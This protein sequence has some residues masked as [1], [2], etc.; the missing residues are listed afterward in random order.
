MGAEGSV[1]MMNRQVARGWGSL[2]SMVFVLAA[3]SWAAAPAATAS[4]ASGSLLSGGAAT[5]RTHPIFMPTVGNQWR[6]PGSNPGALA[7]PAPPCPESG[8][9]PFLFSN[10]GLPEFPA[11]GQP[12]LG[13]MAYWGGHVQVH[14]KIY[15]V[16]WGWG[17]HGAFS[18]A[19]HPERLR[20]GRMTATLP[21]DPDGAGKR[22]A[23]FVDQL[24]GT[25]WAG[26]QTQ[27]YQTVG[28]RN[29]H[30]TNPKDQ[31]GGIWVDDSS[32]LDIRRYNAPTIVQTALGSGDDGGK[33]FRQMGQEAARAVAHF[34][35]KD[36]ADADIVVAQ[37]Q[38]FSDPVA[39]SVGYCAFHDY[40]EPGVEHGQYDG[41]TPGISYTNMPY[42]LNNGAGCGK[43]FVNR[44]GKLDGVTIVL[45]HEI[46]ETVTDPGAEQILPNGKVLSAWFDPFD[47]NENGD[48]C[49]WVGLTPVAVKGVT[50]SE[51][52]EPGA[53]ANITGNHGGRFA[54][55]SLWSN[56]AAAGTGYC[57]GAGNDLGA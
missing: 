2:L 53:A 7:P 12:Y 50:P 11:V 56:E 21:C 39:A 55:Q 8:K 37:P 57:A 15:L 33:I 27:Y 47:G 49:S 17:V 42:V 10:C 18:Q 16:F 25:D 29:I 26:V 34:H 5:A 52:P 44:D 19:C 30:I 40:V 41:I 31:L 48:K 22:M 28:G 4:P 6:A 43:D 54:V 46:E 51:I 13:N 36:L 14:P 1:A 23:D 32:H 38:Y 9:L 45:G 20:E 3:T 24:G 35:V